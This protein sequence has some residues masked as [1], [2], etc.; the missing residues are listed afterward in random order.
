MSV[1][2]G[3]GDILKLKT[4]RLNFNEEDEVEMNFDT[5]IR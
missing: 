4:R 3:I 5:G 1:L 2:S